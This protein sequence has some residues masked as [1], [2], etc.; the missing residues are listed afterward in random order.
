MQESAIRNS[1]QRKYSSNDLSRHLVHWQKDI[2]SGHTENPQNHRLY[3]PAATKKKDVATKRPSAILP[4]MVSRGLSANLRCMFETCC[5]RLAENTGR[6]NLPKIAIWA[7]SHNF[8]GL[9]LSDIFS[10]NVL[11]IQSKANFMAV[12][13]AGNIV[14]LLVNRML[15]IMSILWHTK[16]CRGFSA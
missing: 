10:S 7:P 14:T 13:S 8:V 12:S 5:T 4:H 6:K 15:F 16:C 2:D 3:A 11:V 9:Y 1:C